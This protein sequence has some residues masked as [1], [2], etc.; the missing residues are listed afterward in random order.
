MS[1]WEDKLIEGFSSELWG[2]SFR[3]HFRAAVLVLWWRLLEAAI[4]SRNEWDIY[5]HSCQVGIGF[6]TCRAVTRTHC[7]LSTQ[8][9]LQSKL[10]KKKSSSFSLASSQ[11]SLVP[12]GGW[13]FYTCSCTLQGLPCE[14]NFI[15]FRFLDWDKFLLFVR[16]CTALCTSCTEPENTPRPLT[17]CVEAIPFRNKF[18]KRSLKPRAPQE[19]RVTHR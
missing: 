13:P 18:L 5:V 3:N 19:N 8:S 2:W 16:S 6:S 10:K 17:T 15:L 14:S 4:M 9:T 7:F 12:C 11:D 1:R